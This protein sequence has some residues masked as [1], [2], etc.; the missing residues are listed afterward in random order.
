MKKNRAK[1][2]KIANRSFHIAIIIL[3]YGTIA[4][5]LFYKRDIS[6]IWSSVSQVVN[7]P[8]F[9][10]L[11]SVIFLLMFINIGLEAEKWRFLV[12]KLEKIKFWEATKSV[13][14][15]MT[16]GIF[17]P[18]K[19]G[20]FFGRA[21]V[22]KETNPWK[23]VVV[24][25]IGSFSQ[26]LATL[27]FGTIGV[28][29]MI[30]K[31]DWADPRFETLIF[32][33]GFTIAVI[34]LAFLF[35]FYFKVGIITDL[36]TK[37]LKNNKFKIKQYLRTLSVYSNKELLRVFAYSCSRYLIFSFQFWLSFR[38]FGI[39]LPFIEGL[40]LIAV[41]YFA[42]AVIP[43]IALAELGIRGSVSLFIVQFWSESNG[44][45]Y[46]DLSL[47]IFIA[48]SLIWLV[49]IMLPSLAGTFFVKELNFWRKKS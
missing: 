46:D 40:L 14:T 26:L 31:Y 36:V 2:N 45:L 16:L 32:W 21:F 27:T 9:V 23:G 8:F 15:G 18:Q 38:I 48:S 17:T 22:L 12:L 39:A 11:L 34:I 25:I 3:A 47:Q 29:Y 37:T 43:S 4:Y 20:S 24:S 10:I 28:L 7:D 5:E 33:G 42:L 30:K 1:L 41:I 35:L 19:I 6:T 13:L 49:N 44:L